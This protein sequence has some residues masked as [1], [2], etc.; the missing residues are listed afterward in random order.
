MVLHPSDNSRSDSVRA[1]ISAPISTG[2]AVEALKENKLLLS[3][4]E[5]DWSVYLACPVYV[6]GKVRCLLEFCSTGDHPQ[7]SADLGSELKEQILKLIT[8]WL[9]NELSQL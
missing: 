3:Q 1:E 7:E 8:Q 6:D 2:Q 5:A 9:G 4:N